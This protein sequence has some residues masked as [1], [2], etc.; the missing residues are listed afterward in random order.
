MQRES[1]VFTNGC[2]D[3]IHSGH[4]L[5]L[6]Y[7]AKFGK[8]IVGL[9]SD[10][11]VKRIKGADRPINSELDRK[12]VLESIRF[13]DEVILFDEETPLLLI[14]KIQPDFIVKGGDYRIDEV[15]GNELAEVKIF[16]TIVGKSTSNLINSLKGN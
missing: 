7:S 16:P 15:I 6:E 13:V 9:N 2:F 4:I 3:I 1:L 11:S 10:E 12:L 8:V 5:L 14:R